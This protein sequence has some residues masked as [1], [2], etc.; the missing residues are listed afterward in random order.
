MNFTKNDILESLTP[1][2]LAH[3]NRLFETSS[4]PHLTASKQ[5]MQNTVM[6]TTEFFLDNI[7]LKFA[8]LSRKGL[9]IISSIYRVIIGLRIT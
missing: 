8:G 5:T 1:E 3:F 7:E 6:A 4:S 9:L 2:M